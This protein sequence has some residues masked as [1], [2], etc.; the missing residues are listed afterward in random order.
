MKIALVTHWLSSAGGG[1]TT[2][3]E[4]LSTTLLEVG[5]EVQVFGLS[6]GLW[7]TEQMEW[8]G[9]PAE[10]FP[11]VGPPALGLAPSLGSALRDFAPDVIHTHGIWMFTSATVACRGTS[12]VPYVVSPHGMLDGWALRTSRLKKQIARVLFEDRHLTRASCLHALNQAE[13]EALRDFGLTG[14]VATIPNGITLPSLG[15]QAAPPWVSHFG[16]GAKVLLFLGRLH[17]KK[18]VDGLLRAVATLLEQGQLGDWFVAIAGWGQGGH[19]AELKALACELG[20][21]TR[22]AFLGALHGMDKDA[23]FHHA[24]A[25]VLPS[26]SEGLPMAVLEAWAH[27]LPV[28]MTMACNIPEGFAVG[29][30]KEIGMTPRELVSTLGEFLGCKTDDLTKMGQRGRT[31]V[32]ARFT[33]PVIAERFM[34]VYQW[35]LSGGSAPPEVER[36][37]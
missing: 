3:V 1:V 26:H 4:A 9:A 17:P 16:F 20:L 29:A 37:R 15:E 27:G 22:V 32:G 5:A 34:G 11:T 7:L 25:F 36:L 12:G 8:R 6:D 30:A 10:A 23:A 18:N 24:A 28:A 14:S 33:W 21:G 19:D 2:V 35:M 31:L 13:V